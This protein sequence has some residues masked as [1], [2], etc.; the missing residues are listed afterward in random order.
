MGKEYNKP[1]IKILELT[2]ADVICSSADQVMI[3][4]GE[5]HLYKWSTEW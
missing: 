5:D 2:K 1:S 3:V 4:D